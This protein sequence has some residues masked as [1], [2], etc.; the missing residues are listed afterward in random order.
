MV[1]R[2]TILQDFQGQVRKRT[3]CV[4][5]YEDNHENK[6]ASEQDQQASEWDQNETSARDQNKENVC[7]AS[8]QLGGVTIKIY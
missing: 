3:D 4:L 1:N 2:S 6:E 7:G 8:T 5:G